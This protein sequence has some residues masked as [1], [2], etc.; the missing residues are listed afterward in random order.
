MSGTT[1]IWSFIREVL[2]D[3]W[4]TLPNFCV[5]VWEWIGE[6]FTLYTWALG[7]MIGI[8]WFSAVYV[9]DL[10]SIIGSLAPGMVATLNG[11]S[12]EAGVQIPGPLGQAFSTCNAL[13]PLTELFAFI[14]I[15]LPIYL[16]AVIVRC[17]KSFVPTIA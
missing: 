1:S 13:L 17:V 7:V 9:F 2:Y 11:V 5:A 6:F 15:L 4:R 10:I 3:L 12:G 14:V 16:I 8:L